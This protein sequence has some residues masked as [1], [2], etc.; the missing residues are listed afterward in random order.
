MSGRPSRIYLVGFMGS[1]KSTVGRLLAE[2]LG[3]GFVDLDDEIEALEGERVAAIF[4]R[5]GEEYFRSLETTALLATG[6]VED[7]VVACGG[8]IVLRGENRVALADLGTV[9]RLKVSAAEAVA[10]IG[11]VTSRPILAGAT[12]RI[13]VESILDARRA[14]YRVVADITVDTSGST[15]LEVVDRIVSALDAGEEVR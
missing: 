6:A 9:V 15:P 8:G 7:V 14:L 3:Y 10:R 1:G 11:D 13:G 2:R 5:R 4:E 12:G